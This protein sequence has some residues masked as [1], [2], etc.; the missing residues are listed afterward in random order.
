[1]E[2]ACYGAYFLEMASYLAQ[3]EEAT[4]E[5]IVDLCSVDPPRPWQII[6]ITFTNKAAGELK[7]RLERMLGPA[8]NDVWASTFHSACVRILRRDIDKLGLSSQ[9]TI[10]DTDD[11]QRV[12]K[13][14][15][16]DFN[17][18]DKTY[19]PRTVLGYFSRAKGRLAD[20][21]GLSGPVRKER[22]FPADPD[23]KALC[24]VPAAAVGGQRPGL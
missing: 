22:G 11:S 1:M 9:F 2:G 24:G 14:L 20:G 5:D 19:P 21:A 7:E 15:L 10:Y 4:P 23:C 16:K 6:A 13:E 3:P 8:A 12:V 17:L 18:D